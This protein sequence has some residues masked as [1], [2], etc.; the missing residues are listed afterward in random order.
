MGGSGRKIGNDIQENNLNLLKLINWSLILSG[1][2][3]VLASVYTSSIFVFAIKDFLIFAISFLL[4]LLLFLKNGNVVKL[5]FENII[6]LGFV[7]YVFLRSDNSLSAIASLR[8]IIAPFVIIFIGYASAKCQKNISSRNLK[9][10]LRQIIYVLLVFGFFDVTFNLMSGVTISFFEMKNIGVLENQV[11]AF[12]NE[13]VPDYLKPY[14]DAEYVRRNVSLL[15]DPINL[16]HSLVFLIFFVK[17][18][19]KEFIAKF[20]SLAGL[21]MTFSK[22]AFLQYL[23]IQLDRNKSQRGA[24]KI[25]YMISLLVFVS[26]FIFYV[27]SHPGFIIHLSGLTSALINISVFGYGLGN[28]GNYS[29]LLGVSLDGTIGDSFWGSIIGQIG[30][31]GFLYWI[32]AWLIILKKIKGHRLIKVTILTQLIIGALSENS[33]N[34]LSLFLVLGVTGYKIGSVKKH[35]A[36]NN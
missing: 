1:P 3:A 9:S 20:F 27:I 34:T 17:F 15:L 26:F 21:L 4:L 13:P 14:F 35:A 10:H 24:I 33:L 2:S 36:Q 19:K 28:V 23:L 25:F 6:F 16:G 29:V 7:F 11:P 31:L 5:S 8:Q 18:E 12:W 30:L 32:T 22:G